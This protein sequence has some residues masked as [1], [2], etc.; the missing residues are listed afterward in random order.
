M[1]EKSYQWHLLALT[2][3]SIAWKSNQLAEV[4]VAG[5]T[6]TLSLF[7]GQVSACAHKCPH[8]GG[9]MSEG[10]L[11]ATGKIVCPLHRFKFDTR[12]G[13]NTSG[14]GYYLKTYPVEQREEGL[15]IGIPESSLFNW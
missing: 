12:N 10:F 4:E 1:A 8:S 5:K 9:I 2:A 13:R 3:D 11:D 6:I 15:F 7:E 14:E